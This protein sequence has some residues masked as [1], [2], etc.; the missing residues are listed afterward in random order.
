MA[1]AYV[2]PGVNTGGI[3]PP[4]DSIMVQYGNQQAWMPAQQANAHNNQQYDLAAAG[5]PSFAGG[6][7]PYLPAN[8]PEQYAVGAAKPTNYDQLVEQMMQGGGG[9]G[10]G[11]SPSKFEYGAF[12]GPAAAPG[13]FSYGNFTSQGWDAPDLQEGPGKFKAPTLADLSQD[14]GYQFRLKQGQEALE[15][16]AAAR[17]TLLTGGTAKD[18]ASYQQ[19]LA[20][21][22]FDKMYGRSFGEWQAESDRVFKEN[23]N[24]WDRSLQAYQL[25]YNRLFGEHQQ[26]Y[27][28]A[29][30]AYGF[31][32]Q[33]AAQNYGAAWDQYQHGYQMARDNWQ[34]QEGAAQSAASAG[35]RAERERLAYLFRIAG[36]E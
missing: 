26:G 16:S 12:Q 35:D 2:P 7:N 23:A 6:S 31:A 33:D 14:T 19:D 5:G 24:T 15:R 17:G 28:Q 27:G 25:D 32:Q 10:G 36:L 18:L 11:Y 34:A 29:R 22:E 21:Q 20:S 3:T 30:D 4:A 1:A 9:G 8:A 13:G